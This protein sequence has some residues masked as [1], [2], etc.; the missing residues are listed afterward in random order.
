M[1]TSF[2]HQPEAQHQKSPAIETPDCRLPHLC[3][4][5][6]RVS[7]AIHAVRRNKREGHLCGD[8]ARDHPARDL[9]FHRKAHIIRHMC[10]RHAFGIVR[11]CL[12]QIKR[13]VDKGMA[14]ARHIGR[15][16][17]DLAIGDV[18]R[19]A[20][21]LAGNAARRLALFQKAGL[22]KCENRLLI[23]S[24]F[25]ARNHVRCRATHPRPTGRGPGSPGSVQIFAMRRETGNE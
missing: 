12:R 5:R 11:P 16:H 3:G 2:H 24:R 21:I 13:T 20:G 7:R 8:D 6:F 25:L 14:V 4:A 1:R 10:R 22:V 19:R 17:A 18:A 23:R 15:E 9:R